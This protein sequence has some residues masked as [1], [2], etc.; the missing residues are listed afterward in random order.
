MK[1]LQMPENSRYKPLKSLSQG[2]I[3]MLR[4]KRAGQ[5]KEE[6]VALV[7]AGGTRANDGKDSTEEATPHAPF[8][9]NI[10]SY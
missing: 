8:E 2:G 4:D 1:T 3:I 9:I 7:A 5:E 10:A 6:I